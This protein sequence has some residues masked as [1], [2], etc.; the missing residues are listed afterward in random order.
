MSSLILQSL[1]RVHA[2]RI[3]RLLPCARP[4]KPVDRESHSTSQLQRLPTI[5]AACARWLQTLP[6]SSLNLKT[7]LTL[8][9]AVFSLTYCLKTKVCSL[10]VA[11]QLVDSRLPGKQHKYNIQGTQ[12]LRASIQIT[13]FHFMQVRSLCD[14]SSPCNVYYTFVRGKQK[15]H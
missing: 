8:Q 15:G 7:I 12:M 13:A 5:P 10:N 1:H 11:F 6:V 4:V 9:T 3:T 2:S 14:L